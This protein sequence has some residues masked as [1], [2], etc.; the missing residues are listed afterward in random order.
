MNELTIKIALA[1][2]G[3]L[4]LAGAVYLFR[5]RIGERAKSILLGLVA[6]AE[7]HFG[8]GTGEIKLSSVLGNLYARTPALLQ[9]LFPK[10]TVDGWVE[11]AL[12]RFKEMLGEV[13]DDDGI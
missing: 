8:A 5:G 9:L 11:D 12:A 6:E 4:F 10:E 2:L 3:V 13:A 7:E 1:V